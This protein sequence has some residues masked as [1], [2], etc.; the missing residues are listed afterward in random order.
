[1]RNSSQSSHVSEMA[2][3]YLSLLCLIIISG[4]V[5]DFA[6]R[7]FFVMEIRRTIIGRLGFVFVELRFMYT[8]AIVT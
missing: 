5:L 8:V 6:R 7:M 2:Y 3:S 4:F 1:M